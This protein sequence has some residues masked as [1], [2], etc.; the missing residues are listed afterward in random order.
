MTQSVKSAT[1]PTRYEVEFPF[2]RVIVCTVHDHTEF[3]WKPGVEKSEERGAHGSYM[4]YFAHGLG[5][6]VITEI[7]RVRPP[8]FRERVI[9][10]RTWIDP[11]GLPMGNARLLRMTSGAHFKALVA[12]YRQPYEMTEMER[13]DPLWS[14]EVTE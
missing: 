1:S 13:A 3:G 12:G 7:A 6:M 5:R 2:H 4:A 9:Y 11:S 10:T 8:G 14:R